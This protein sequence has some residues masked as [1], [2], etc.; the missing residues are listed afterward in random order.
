MKNP[1]PARPSRE[2]VRE[3]C[4]SPEYT[5]LLDYLRET[6]QEIITTLINAPPTDAILIARQ[7]MRLAWLKHFTSGEVVPELVKRVTLNGT[8]KP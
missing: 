3:F 5:L 6:E 2:S 4:E 8:T 1:P 7:Q